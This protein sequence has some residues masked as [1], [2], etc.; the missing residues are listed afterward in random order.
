[1]QLWM[2][3]IAPLPNDGGAMTNIQTKFVVFYGKVDERPSD[4]YWTGAQDVDE[5]FKPFETKADAIE[6]ALRSGAGRLPGF[7]ATYVPHVRV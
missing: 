1:M 4:W 6:H 7:V 2:V 3:G 5:P